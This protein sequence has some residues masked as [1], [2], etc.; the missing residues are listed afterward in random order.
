MR[1]ISGQELT[2]LKL[3]PGE[4][5]RTPLMVLQFWKGG[6]WIRAQNIWR[7]W[8]LAYNVPHTTGNTHEPTL[9][10]CSSHQFAEM[11]KANE[12]NQI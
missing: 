7:R 6:D 12:E 2:H 9:A 11:I 3:L 4:E 5:I 10:A 8:M 1:I